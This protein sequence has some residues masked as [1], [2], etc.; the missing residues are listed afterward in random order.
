MNRNSAVYT[1]LF[2]L[3]V[4]AV[5]SVVVAGTFVA[6]AERQRADAAIARMLDIL[7]L[8][9]LA[10][11]E[12][13]LT[14]EEIVE[15]FKVIRPRA[16]NMET[17]Q[18][19]DEVDAALFD[20]R[21]ASNDPTQSFMAPANEAGV[22]RVPDFAIVYERLGENGE[23]DQIL[24]PIHGQGYGG[25]IYG[26]LSLGPDLNT[27]RQIVFYEHQETPTLGGR[28]NRKSWRSNWPGRR[29]FDE[30]GNVALELVPKPPPAE[31]APYQV[32]AVS[33]ATVTTAG[34]QNMINFWFGPDAFQPF[35]AEYRKTLTASASGGVAGGR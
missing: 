21:E 26:F 4:C 18:F 22:R 12:E 17:R 27:V 10:E 32:D 34:V 20:Q 2:T 7:R 13:E 15:R 3:A 19:D 16:V 6:L 5:C 31:E 24:I 1:L 33:R 29:I 8:T 23:L 28:I 25:Q 30:S 11:S 35:L 14:K 9:E